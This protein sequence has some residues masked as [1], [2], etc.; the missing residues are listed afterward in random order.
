M[1]LGVCRISCVI[2]GM[3]LAKFPTALFTIG[4]AYGM[5]IVVALVVCTA[6]SGGHFS[7][8]VTIVHTLFNG[9]PPTKAARLVKARWR[10]RQTYVFVKVYHCPDSRWPFR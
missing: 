9:F 8:A 1:A 4:V 5:G 6:T 7:P 2:P 3:D 10:F